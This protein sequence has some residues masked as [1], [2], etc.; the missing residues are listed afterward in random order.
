MFAAKNSF[1]ANGYK[2]PIAFD[3]LM[4]AGGGG[5]GGGFADSNGAGGGGAG[6]F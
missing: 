5:G 3:Y 4:V 2:G 1:I 6:G